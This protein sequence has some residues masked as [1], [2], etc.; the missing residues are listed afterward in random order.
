MPLD[1]SAKSASA[2]IRERLDH[3]VLDGDG[4]TIEYDPIFL[5]Y[6]HQVAGPDM[7]KRYERLGTKGGQYYGTTYEDRFDKRMAR[8]PYWGNPT[9]NTLDRATAMA[10]NLLRAR[11]D[12]IGIDFSILHTS[13]LH[14]NRF[15]DEEIRRAG[16]RA[17]NT[18]RAEM[19]R[20]HGDRMTPSASIPMHTPE[21]AIEELEYAVKVLGLKTIMIAG[22]VRRP[23]P[24]IAREAPALARYAQWIDNLSVG[25]PY[26]YDPFWAKCAELKVAPMTH[27]SGIWGSRGDTKNFVFNHLGHFAASGEAF[28]RGL[29]MGGVT[30]RFPTLRF[31]FMEGGVNWACGLYNDLFE[32]WEKRSYKALR[33]N[34]DPAQIDRKGLSDLLGEYGGEVFAK[35]IAHVRE[36]GILGIP[37]EDP[38]NLDDFAACKITSKQDIYDL[39]VPPFH[40]GCEADDRMNHGAFDTKANRMGAR[41]KATFS[42]DIGHWDVQ[43][44]SEVLVE[45]YENVEHGLMTEDDFQDMT[46]TNVVSLVGTLN[47]N[48]FKG[49]VVESAVAKLDPKKLTPAAQ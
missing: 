44:M 48:F 29:F 41:L 47:P 24:I 18:M 6:L 36:H 34:L 25:S 17:L 16:C 15:P 33:E 2:K 32:H 42:S 46:F 19:F 35:H 30:R 3:P 45:A 31:G 40:F 14:L 9:R 23:V 28:C 37:E 11:M 7:V 1:K 39:F 22:V 27:T 4:H 10:P 21:E 38:N 8:I 20:G 43:D 12:E 26:N 13:A 5:E 49:T